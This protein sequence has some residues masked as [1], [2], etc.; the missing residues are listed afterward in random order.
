MSPQWR[1]GVDS[2]LITTLHVLRK[3]HLGMQLGYL[4]YKLKKI[5][6]MS[7]PVYFSSRSKQEHNIAAASFLF[8][9]FVFPWKTRLC[10]G[11]LLGEC[12]VASAC[13]WKPCRH[14]P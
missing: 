6:L 2:V 12:L 7:F 13:V 10:S 3:R 8:R 14:R 1:G 4:D 11:N 9:G 5:F